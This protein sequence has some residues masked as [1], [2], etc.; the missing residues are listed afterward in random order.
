MVSPLPPGVLRD[1]QER[2]LA[3][4]MKEARAWRRDERALRAIA[5]GIAKG[6]G[7]GNAREPV[8]T[9]AEEAPQG[10]ADGKGKGRRDASAARAAWNRDQTWGN[11]GWGNQ[12]WGSQGWAGSRPRSHSRARRGPT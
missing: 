4:V 10:D 11:Q 5:Q 3:C 2:A 9:A 1:A 8:A 7:K 12:G 6:K